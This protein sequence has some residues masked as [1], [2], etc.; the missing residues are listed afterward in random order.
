MK[1]VMRGTVAGS[2]T[3]VEHE[4]KRIKNIEAT[5]VIFSFVRFQHFMQLELKNKKIDSKS[6]KIDFFY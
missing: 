3:T 2:P 5:R 6:N 4:L 1:L